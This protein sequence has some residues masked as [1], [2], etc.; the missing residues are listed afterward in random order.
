MADFRDGAGW[1]AAR[2][3]DARVTTIPGAGHLAP[4]EQPDLFR[5]LLIDHLD[6]IRAGH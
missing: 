2:L 3:R 6:V 5:E 1:I 4:L